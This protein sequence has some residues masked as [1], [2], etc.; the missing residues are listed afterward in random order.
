MAS[1]MP[2]RT[3]DD[4][5]E[6]DDLFALPSPEER[7]CFTSPS[8]PKPL[9]GINADHRSSRKDTP[10]F[11]F[12]AAGYYESISK[13]GGIPVIIPPLQDEEDIAHT[14]DSLDGIVLSGGADLDPR[15]DGFMLHPAIRLLDRRREE[16][17]RMLMRL[18]AQRQMPVLGIGCGMQLLNVS[19]GGNLF[20]HIPEDLPHALP[21][22]D[23]SDPNHRHALVVEKDSLMDRLYGES[24]IRVSS[25]H[26]MAVDEVAPGFAVTARC[27]DGV[28]E[29]IESTTDDWFALGVQFHPEEDRGTKLDIGIFELF[30]DGVHRSRTLRMVA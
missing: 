23:T 21:H 17:D 22:L 18:V 13:A 24:E 15:L 14:L 9:I 12:L 4:R 27:P 1:K 16:F 25:L 10:A 8:V 26:H 30:V 7:A 3:H 19:Q 6:L 11:S 28:I 29:A 5:A 2:R 20:L